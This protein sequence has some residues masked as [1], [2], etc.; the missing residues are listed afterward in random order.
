VLKGFHQF[1]VVCVS[2]SVLTKYAFLSVYLAHF[3]PVLTKVAIVVCKLKCV[4]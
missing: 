3:D 4:Q 2:Y 1:F